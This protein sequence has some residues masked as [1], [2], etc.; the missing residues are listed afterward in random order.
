MRKYKFFCTVPLL[1]LTLTLRADQVMIIPIKG[2]IDLGLSAFVKRSVT[3]A[4]NNHISTIILEIDTPGGRLD[5]ADLICEELLN[6]KGKTIAF[7]LNR[8]WSAGSMIALASD[9]IIMA[10]GSS[11]G[12]A[13][14]RVGLSGKEIHDEKIISALRARFRAI[15]ETKNHNPILAEAMVDKDLEIKEAIINGEKKIINLQQ[16]QNSEIKNIQIIKTISPKGKLLNL[17]YLEAQKLGLAEAICKDRETLLA[18]L[19]KESTKIIIT[20]PNWS[21]NLVRFITHPV[22]SSLLLGIGFW[23]LVI[24]LKIPGM[25]LPEFVGITALLLFFWGY[26]LTGLAHWIEFLLLILGLILIFIEIFILPGFGITGSLGIICLFSGIILSFLK[27]PL[28]LPWRDLQRVGIILLSAVFI[29][30]TFL[31]VS[32]KL[33]SPK[34]GRR[35][36]ILFETSKSQITPLP[37]IMP[38]DIGTAISNLRPAGKAKIKEKIYNVQTSG[39]WI[40]QGEKI[41]VISQDG[42]VIRVK[43]A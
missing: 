14:P 9:K 40:E 25:G 33:L 39:E 24:A 17:S 22:V 19:G 37:D 3:Y 21:E 27:Y 5:A 23:A 2:V 4:W 38:G 12:S 10:P 31:F 6:F 20:K 1:F 18:Y 11:I 28:T 30:G 34:K 13:E 36:I 35:G 42:N 32:F 26:K 29:T 7:V 16:L 41:K 43:K 15:A 8:A